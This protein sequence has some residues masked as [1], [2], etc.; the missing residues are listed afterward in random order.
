MKKL[1]IFVEGQ[2]EQ[3]FVEKL[4]TEI[5]GKHQLQI[6]KF[7]AH[8]GKQSP[9][10]LSQLTATQPVNDTRYYVQIVDCAGDGRVASDVRDN[11]AGLVSS[12]FSGIIGLRDVA[13]DFTREEVPRLLQRLHFGIKTKPIQVVFVLSV[14]EI[15]A[16]FLAEHTHL[17]RLCDTVDCTTISR[18]I[19]FDITSFDVDM[20]PRPSEDLSTIYKLMGL[21]YDKSRD[22]V[23]QTVNVLEYERVYLELPKRVP[24]LVPLIQA[25]DSFLSPN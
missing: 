10:R 3:L 1:A 25:I 14:M 21:T 24:G 5:A 9:R 7:K 8:G 22:V 4:V 19:G 17:R 16:W 12:E 23:Q 20:R 18:H 6:E 15:E 2:T 11:Y 13:P